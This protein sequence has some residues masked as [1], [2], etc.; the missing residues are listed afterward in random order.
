MNQ[1]NSADE[2]ETIGRMADREHDLL[3]VVD[4][5]RDQSRRAVDAFGDESMEDQA[6]EQQDRKI[7]LTLW[8][9][10]PANFQDHREEQRVYAEHQQRIDEGPE[11]AE[12]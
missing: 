11:Q 9:I 1:W 12:H 2:Q 5:S 4:V 3:D 10:A 8:L 7:R 6:D